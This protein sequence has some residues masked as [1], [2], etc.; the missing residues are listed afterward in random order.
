MEKHKNWFE[1]M[2]LTE[3]RQRMPRFLGGGEIS[4]TLYGWGF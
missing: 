2:I 3:G 1:K 4:M